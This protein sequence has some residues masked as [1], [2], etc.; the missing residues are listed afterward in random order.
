MSVHNG[1]DT[2]AEAIESVL[3]Q[4]FTNFE[5]IIIDDG[6]TDSSPGIIAQYAEK[7]PRIRVIS[8][9]N[10]GLTRALNRGLETCSA[11]FVARAD[12]DDRSLPERLARQVRFMEEHPDVVL[13][14]SGVHLLNVQR[15]IYQTVLAPQDDDSV[16]RA[17]RKRN[18]FFH[19]A[20]M[21][22][23]EVVRELGGYDPDFIRS[24]DYDLWLRLLDLGEGANLPQALVELD[25]GPGRVSRRQ[26]RKQVSAA[27]KAKWKNRKGR[28]LKGT[29][30]HVFWWQ[31]RGYI[32]PP[33]S[34]NAIKAKRSG[35]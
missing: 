28:V 23:A 9:Q 33:G 10:E 32:I 1:S 27:I 8:Q 5:F 20:V 25:Q 24:Q 2:V 19:S 11:P 7:D 3:A 6:S 17:M 13:V 31:L 26:A 21:M 35:S 34:L 16:R 29:P 15:E 14:G 22:R 4:S 30:P 12:A 18:I